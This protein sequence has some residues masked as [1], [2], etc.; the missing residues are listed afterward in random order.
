MEQYTQWYEK[1]YNQNLKDLFEFLR[2][3]SIGTDPKYDEEVGKCANWVL[4]YLKS[5]GFITRIIN[6]P[7]HPVI[8]GE[9]IQNPLADTVLIYHHYDVQPADPYD[10][11]DSDPFDPTIREDN[12][13][14]RGAQDNKGQCFYTLIAVKAFLEYT[15]SKNINLKF[16]IEGDEEGGS[17]GLTEICEEYQDLLRADHLLVVDSSIP[18]KDTPGIGL[19]IRG[20]STMEVKFTVANTDL[21]S[22]E[23]GGLVYN[24]IRALSEVL[25]KMWYENG[26]I[27]IPHFYD[28]VVSTTEEEK[29]LFDHP[30]N[31]EDYKKRFG[32]RKMG[33]ESGYTPVQSNCMRPTVEINGIYGGFTGHGFK[34]VLPKEAVA[35]IS[36]RLVPNQDPKKIY[37]RMVHFIQNHAPK[38]MEV[39]FINHGGGF[40]AR[41]SHQSKIAKVCKKAYE[42]IFHKECEMHLIGGSIPI[43]AKLAKISGADS[44]FIGMGLMEDNIHAPNEHFSLDRVKKG[45]LTIVKI[46]TLLN[47]HE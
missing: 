8:Y 12:I 4:S 34:T 9:Y 35:K 14:A 47:N 39:A 42:D 22:G 44:V 41:A 31:I 20:I 1:H 45:F 11:W 18:D 5:L 43:A 27:A 3:K 19:G 7:M 30:F 25:A 2:F 29:K 33:V 23:H 24:P 36:C 21:H 10:L 46:L 37:E 28:E 17:K 13:F 40:A 15:K 16:C 26:K 38:D 32:I 6:T